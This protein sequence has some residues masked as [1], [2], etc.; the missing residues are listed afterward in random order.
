MCHFNCFTNN[1][2]TKRRMMY[3]NVQIQHFEIQINSIHILC[4]MWPSNLI[5]KRQTPKLWN[6][7]HY[8]VVVFGNAPDSD[9]NITVWVD[10]SLKFMVEG[11]PLAPALY[12]L[13]SVA[14]LHCIYR[15]R[16]TFCH[17]ALFFIIVA[18]FQF[19]LMTH[20]F[21]A[22]GMVEPGSHC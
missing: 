21:P 15:T 8:E 3:Q 7:H 18:P 6:F 9:A 2:F 4:E 10:Q 5:L 11:S 12:A 20:L 16:P 19:T 17:R 22:N 1:Y 14:K 13:I